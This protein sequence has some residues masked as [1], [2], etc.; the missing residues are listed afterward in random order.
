MSPDTARLREFCDVI[1]EDLNV[2]RIVRIS[3]V[4]RD[5]GYERF[6]PPWNKAIEIIEEHLSPKSFCTPVT[7]N[8]FKRTRRRGR[9]TVDV[10]RDILVHTEEYLGSR[11]HGRDSTA[12][13]CMV[14]YCG[15]VL[16][17][18]YQAQRRSQG[19]SVLNGA[20]Q[21]GELLTNLGIPLITDEDIP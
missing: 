16:A 13:Y 14:D 6:S 9:T 2:R 18:V 17:R 8:I 11:R 1:K 7:T 12:G 20:N 21:L 10:S 4:E 15:G 19:E 5:L 3:D